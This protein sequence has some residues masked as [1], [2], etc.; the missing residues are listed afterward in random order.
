MEDIL[1]DFKENWFLDETNT[2]IAKE[3][4]K[5]EG[6]KQTILFK[7]ESHELNGKYFEECLNTIK[8][9]L[10]NENLVVCLTPIVGY[11]KNSYVVNDITDIET[12]KTSIKNGFIVL[13]FAPIV[14]DGELKYRTKILHQFIKITNPDVNKRREVDSIPK[15]K[16]TFEEKMIYLIDHSEVIDESYFRSESGNIY[17]MGDKRINCLIRSYQSDKPIYRSDHI[18]LNEIGFKYKLVEDKYNDDYKIV[19]EEILTK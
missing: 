12:I 8:P 18:K 2:G 14:V 5:E 6:F 4:H 3:H 7:I 15:D 16:R 9:L 19:I 13:L 11:Q 1:K 17:E 10:N